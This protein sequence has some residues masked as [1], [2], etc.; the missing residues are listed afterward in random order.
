[1]QEEEEE[2][3]EENEKKKRMKKNKEKISYFDVLVEGIPTVRSLQIS[4]FVAKCVGMHLQA[5]IM[6][7]HHEIC[8]LLSNT[9]PNRNDVGFVRPHRI[10]VRTNVN[11]T[12]IGHHTRIGMICE[13]ANTH[14][15][16][17][18]ERVRERETEK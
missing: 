11:Q 8:W 16:F 6:A 5:D 1:V 9:G 10:C 12:F 7:A 14:I 17:E 18:R 3:E 2:E 4:A 13:G 15:E